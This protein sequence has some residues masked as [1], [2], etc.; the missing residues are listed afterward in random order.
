[1][2]NND[3]SSYTL[4]WNEILKQL[5][6][7]AGLNWVVASISGGSGITQLTGDVTA[8]PGTGSQA[9]TLATVNPDVGSFTSANITV[10]AKGQVTAASNGTSGLLLNAYTIQYN[11]DF[12][13]T[14]N[15]FV[16]TPLT[17][18]VPVTSPT[19][20]FFLSWSGAGYGTVDPSAY[21]MLQNGSPLANSTN[22]MTLSASSGT[23][24][25]ISGSWTDSPATMDP[26]ITYALGIAVFPGGGTGTAHL[27]NGVHGISSSLT[28][29]EFAS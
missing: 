19:S 5:E 23:L 8:G 21:C 11:D 18:T 28:I 10:N 16:A 9:A 3:T 15:T 25:T 17:I 14:S 27:G 13:T 7:S 6:Y 12:S 29:M 4:R 24:A 20:R 2:A 26:T 1:M 22:G